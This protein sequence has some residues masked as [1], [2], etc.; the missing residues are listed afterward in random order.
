[1]DVKNII[2]L[3]VAGL[4]LILSLLV[5]SKNTKNIINVAYGSVI[6]S[7]GIWSYGI[8]MFRYSDNV[9][10]ALL[11]A[12]TYYIAA[13]LIALFFLIFSIHFPYKSFIL[14]KIKSL[15]IILP[16]IVVVIIIFIPDMMI[17]KISINIPTNV[18]TL[19]SSYTIY[20]M[21]F[22]SYMAISFY[23]LTKKYASSQGI[24]A[25]QLKYTL[26]ATATATFFGATFNLILPMLGNYKLIW[27][28]PYFTLITFAYVSY[29]LFFN[30]HRI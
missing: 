6:L 7:V 18:V 8:A 14:S 20:T 2:L 26:N 4:N 5:Y 3:I 24:H 9:I 11:W 16:F 19:Q 21:Y 15:L 27:L 25:I 10:T 28:G 30:K 1:M 23:Y 17:G 12:R 22:L 29:Y 13:A